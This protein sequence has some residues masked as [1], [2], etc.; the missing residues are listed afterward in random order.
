M[1]CIFCL[2]QLQP[3]IDGSVCKNAWCWG[4]TGD[5]WVWGNKSGYIVYDCC[6]DDYNNIL[7]WCEQ[8][9]L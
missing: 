3:D 5:F 6:V 4:K 8:H 1:Q 7:D 9:L 2:E